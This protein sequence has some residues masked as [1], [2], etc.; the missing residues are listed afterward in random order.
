MRYKIFLRV[1]ASFLIITSTSH[2]SFAMEVDL[3][4]IENNEE[5]DIM[6]AYGGGKLNILCIK[7]HLKDQLKRFSLSLIKLHI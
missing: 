4:K 3:E 5:L 1:A 6:Q 2:S 7:I